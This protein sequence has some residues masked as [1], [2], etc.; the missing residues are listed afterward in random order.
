[1]KRSRKVSLSL[2]DCLNVAFMLGIIF[3]MLYPLYYMAIVSISNGGS[4]S[5]GEVGFLPVDIT[6][7]AY[8]IVFT[9]APIVQAFWNTLLY[10][11][12]GVAINLTMTCLCAYPLSRKSFHGRNVFAMLI[13]FTMFFDGGLIPKYL[14]IDSLGMINTIWAI[15]LPPSI[16]I[17]YMVM[18]RTFFQEIPEA[19]HESAY[20]D[21][22]N[23]WT[24]FR[25]VVL[26]LSV[27][28]MATMTLFYA[29]GH[30]NSFFSALVYLNDR[31]K[32]PLQIILR[33]IVVEGDTSN[34]AT[35]MSGISGSLII[36][37]NIKY[38]VVIIAI[39]PILLLYPFLQKYFV[40]GAMVGSLK[41]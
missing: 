18:M 12:V 15:V 19:L 36:S 32:Y 6:W 23:D 4:V 17:M 29:V 28:L 3:I 26:P 31:S 37:Q 11:T 8:E 13:V 27:P 39:L 30:W 16:S 34:Q 38:A 41:G 7:K 25:K 20:I 22:A 14:L 2:F 10:T 40:K 1:M 24:V 33:S 21:G 35:E 5:R 9:D